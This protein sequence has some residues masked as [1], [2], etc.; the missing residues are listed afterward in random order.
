MLQLLQKQRQDAAPAAQHVAEPH[1]HEPRRGENW[2]H[3]PNSLEFGIVSPILRARRLGVGHDRGK[4][5]FGGVRIKSSRSASPNAVGRCLCSPFPPGFPAVP[6]HL[7]HTSVVADPSQNRA[8][9]IY[10][11]GSSHS[12]FTE[13]PNILTLILGSGRGKRLSICLNFSRLRQ[14]FFPLRL[15]HLNS[16]FLT[17]SL[18]LIIPFRLSV[19]P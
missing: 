5:I 2:G 18:N 6:H 1:G 4:G 16:S 15:S 10:A 9:A 7:N 14:F 13:N 19:T 8:C 11:H 17:S 12:Q 3:D